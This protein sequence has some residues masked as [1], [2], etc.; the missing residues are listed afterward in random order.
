[1]LAPERLGAIAVPAQDVVGPEEVVHAFWRDLIARR[2]PA[3]RPQKGRLV[4]DGRDAAN[5]PAAE[6]TGLIGEDIRQ[7]RVEA[8]VDGIVLDSAERT[9]GRTR[10]APATGSRRLTAGRRRHL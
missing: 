1:M 5:R 9:P 2:R 4:A 10:R 6:R 7:D 8:R 3:I